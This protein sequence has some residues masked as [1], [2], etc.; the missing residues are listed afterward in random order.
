MYENCRVVVL[1]LVVKKNVTY[2]DL[3]Y[4]IDTTCYNILYQSDTMGYNITLRVITTL[5]KQ[6]RGITTIPK[7]L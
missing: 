4:F 7:T 6:L 1:Y 5:K 2:S 3:M